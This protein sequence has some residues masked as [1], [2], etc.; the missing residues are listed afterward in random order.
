M[1][2]G[3]FYSI[4]FKQSGRGLEASE[5]RELSILKVFTTERMF[6]CNLL[7]EKNAHFFCNIASY[8]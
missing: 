7:G 5:K 8:L 1:L 4:D 6:P 3:M 2:Q